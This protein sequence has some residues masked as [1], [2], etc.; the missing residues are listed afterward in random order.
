LFDDAGRTRANRNPR[1]R[2]IYLAS[3]L[4]EAQRLLLVGRSGDLSDA[5]VT[6]SATAGG[7]DDLS[8]VEQ[9]ARMYIGLAER[10][11]FEVSVLDDHRDPDGVDSVTL[12]VS[13]A[14]PATLL[15]GE[16]GLHQVR[17]V[18]DPTG[19]QVVR[20]EVLPVPV[21]APVRRELR[22]R[23]RPIAMEGRLGAP[24]TV[25]LDVGFADR[26]GRV[27]VWAADGEP[28]TLDDVAL[29]LQ[30]RRDA[31]DRV[32]SAVIVRRY[33]LGAEAR[34]RDSQSGRST[35][36]AND[37]LR[38]DLDAFLLHSWS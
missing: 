13:G 31:P 24:R 32:G 30:A 11:K 8:A 7:G 28:P 35:G 3:E 20:V 29:L 33:D 37:V 25:E 36:R 21:V 27:L 38:G 17:H 6:V 15:A 16:S 2:A 19:R 12:A 5:F 1:S 26:P 23:S 18:D 22:V 34:V 9:L 4:L 10:W 14:G